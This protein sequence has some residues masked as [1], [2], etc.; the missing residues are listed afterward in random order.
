MLEKLL[1]SPAK[2]AL[3]IEIDG[4]FLRCFLG[5]LDVVRDPGNPG[6]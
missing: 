4:D 3:I 6:P 2:T 5:C 1:R